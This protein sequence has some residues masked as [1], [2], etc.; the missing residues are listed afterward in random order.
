[1]AVEKTLEVCSSQ[2]DN[3]CKFWITCETKIIK[4]DR[5]YY[6]QTRQEHNY[7]SKQIN[8][9]IFPPIPAP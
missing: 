2:F 7:Q 6:V 4:R 9:I 1:M 3:C 8:K 5:L